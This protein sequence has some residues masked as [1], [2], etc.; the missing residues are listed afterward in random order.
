[1]RPVAKHSKVPNFPITGKITANFSTIRE[2]PDGWRG[3]QNGMHQNRE[4]TGNSKDKAAKS[5]ALLKPETRN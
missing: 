3:F 4:L 2:N 1:M 5:A